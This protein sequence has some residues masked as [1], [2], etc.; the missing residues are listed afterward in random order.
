MAAKGA[1]LS[2]ERAMVWQIACGVMTRRSATCSL[3]YA[4]KSSEE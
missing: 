4:L 2:R 1:E 3:H